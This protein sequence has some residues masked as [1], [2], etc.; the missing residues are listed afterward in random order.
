MAGRD[1]VDYLELTCERGGSDLHLTVGAPPLVRVHGVM[2]PLED[3]NLDKEDCENLILNI[4][5]QAQRAILEDT[6]E[7]D[8]AIQVEVVGRFRGNI[9]YNRG[10]LEAAFRRI[11]NRIPDLSELGHL[12]V[13]D[14]ICKLRE[15]LV[16]V[17]GV[18]GSGKSTTL[19]SM[20]KRISETRS[21]V[22]I[23]VEDPI[24]YVFEHSM[25][26]V[27]QREVGSDTKSF[28]GALK[29]V[30]RQDPDVILISELRD[31][32]TIQAAVTASETG[33]LVISTLHT[34]DAPKAID[35]LIDVFP[36]NQQSQIIAQLANALQ[37]VIA[38]RLL[39][40]I[41]GG[42]RVLATEVMLNNN[43]IRSCI[44]GNKLGQLLGLMEIGTGDG[45][46]TIDQSVV[47]L[48]SEEIISKEEAL[49]NCRDK[50]RIEE[51]KLRPKGFLKRKG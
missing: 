37:A 32:E 50:A 5:T 27:K 4:L 43:A 18:T 39:P 41:N 33:H 6:W 28:S 51:I 12:P 14:E 38:Q 16:L 7:L 31:L 40:R 47:R 46:H 10:R 45:M 22:I 49:A 25:S 29:H 24:E 1:L 26:I 3:F 2:Q 15:G 20:V 36:G 8:F 21:G 19:A 44:R 23:S 30:L 42:E 13:V 9:H 11:S 34:I 48:Y 35:R 17:T